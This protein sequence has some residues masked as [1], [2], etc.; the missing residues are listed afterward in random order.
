MKKRT[1]IVYVIASAL[2]AVAAFANWLWTMSTYEAT[3]YELLTLASVPNEAM[4]GAIL[5][6]AIFVGV[7]DSVFEDKNGQETETEKRDTPTDQE[8]D[9]TVVSSTEEK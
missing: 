8:T 2:L 6:I 3:S 7:A 9:S 5:T 1:D 4:L